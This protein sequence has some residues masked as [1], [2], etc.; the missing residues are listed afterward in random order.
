MSGFSESDSGVFSHDP[1]SDINTG[2]NKKYVVFIVKTINSN[3]YG[4]WFITGSGV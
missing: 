1:E 2:I 4:C 3:Y